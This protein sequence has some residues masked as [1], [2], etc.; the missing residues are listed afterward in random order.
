MPEISIDSTL[1]VVDTSTGLVWMKEDFSYIKNRFLRDWN[2]VFEWEEEIN[3]QPYAG[4][5]DW[6]VPDISEYRTINSNEKDRDIY[7]QRFLQADTI[8]IWG[9]GPYAFW[10]ATTPNKNTASYISFI[11]GFA[12]SG[13]RGKQM[14]SGPWKGHEFGISVRLVRGDKVSRD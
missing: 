13:S 6:R 4:C 8:C 2:E 12:T 7:R 10:S 14:A 5:N 9:K 11:D 1:I 3:L